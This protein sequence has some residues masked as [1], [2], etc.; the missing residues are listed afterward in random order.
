MRKLVIHPFLLAIFPV[1][2][3][4]SRNADEIAISELPFC[5]WPHS[6]GLC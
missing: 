4:Y 3:L 1:V 6:A 5:C 2:Y